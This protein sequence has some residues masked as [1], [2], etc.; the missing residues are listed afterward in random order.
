MYRYLM[1]LGELVYTVLEVG[2]EP[3]V[4]DTRGKVMERTHQNLQLPPRGTQLR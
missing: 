2:S 4:F 1:V 3:K